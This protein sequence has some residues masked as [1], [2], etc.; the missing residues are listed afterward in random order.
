MKPVE[1]SQQNVVFAKDQPQYMPLP[2]FVSSNGSLVTSCW[3]MT[4]GERLRNLITGR[5]Y[6]SLLTFGQPLQPQIISI[7]PP[8][9]E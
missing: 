6:V 3:R 8:A 2:A 9:V 5:V 1:F 7:K 4:W